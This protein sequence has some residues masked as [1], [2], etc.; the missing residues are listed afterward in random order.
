M[1]VLGVEGRKIDVGAVRREVD[2]GKC[3]LSGLLVLSLFHSVC[4]RS[5]PRTPVRSGNIDAAHLFR[6]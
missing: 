1:V 2:V 6:A 5:A 4:Y 3:E